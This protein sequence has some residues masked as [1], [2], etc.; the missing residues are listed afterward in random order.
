[1]NLI[2]L[3]IFAVSLQ[4][5]FPYLA[6]V[7]EK[8]KESF[9]SEWSKL[10]DNELGV[11]FN[12][13]KEKIAKA[14]FGYGK[15][16]LDSMKLQAKFQKT[17]KYDN[18]SYEEASLEVYQNKDY[19][20]D[21]YLPGILLSHFLWRHHYLQHKFF[22]EKFMPII[23]DGTNKLFYDVG[24]GTGFYS[25]EILTRSKN[26]IGEGYDLSPFSLSHTTALLK[27]HNVD[28]RYKVNK[29]DI[30]LTKDIPLADF[31]INI[32]VLE[33]LENPQEFLFALNRMLKIGGYGLISAAINAPNSDHIYLYSDPGEVASQLNKA[34]F[35]IIDTTVDKAYEPRSVSE[36]VPVNVAFIVRREK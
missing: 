30:V 27:L 7:I 5:K 12:G 3:E 11:F 16:A 25:K 17:K 32:E 18:K 10:F 9:G 15:F 4:S 21:L 20:F 6:G 14:V 2:N 34:G 13:D 24:V 1:M 26:I 29:K 33:H 19:M 36:L 35:D 31:I 23:D 22:V 8:Q 28:Y